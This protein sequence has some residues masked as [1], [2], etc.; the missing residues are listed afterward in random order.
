MVNSEDLFAFVRE[1]TEYTVRNAADGAADTPP[2]LTGRD[3]ADA[4]M[5][6]AKLVEIEGNFVLAQKH[7]AIH[8]EQS[9]AQ[10]GATQQAH[11]NY[12]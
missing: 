11:G 6:I 12:N 2:L 7:I 8:A 1:A 4:I 5:S 3:L 10:V 9:G